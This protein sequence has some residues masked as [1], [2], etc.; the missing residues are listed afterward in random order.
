[1]KEGENK[2][3]ITGCFKIVGVFQQWFQE[4]DATY[5]MQG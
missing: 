1:M 5:V 3:L 2:H 4:F